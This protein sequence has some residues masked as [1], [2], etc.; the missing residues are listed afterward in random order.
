MIGAAEKKALAKLV[1][2]AT[3]LKPEE[4]PQVN[5][6]AAQP[7]E[8]K[9]KGLT[10]AEAED[11]MNKGE[12][13]KLPEWCGFWFKN[14]K[15]DKVFVFT[16]DGDILDTPH[17]EHKERNDWEVTPPSNPDVSKKLKEFQDSFLDE[18]NE[19]STIPDARPETDSKESSNEIELHKSLEEILPQVQA[20]KKVKIK[21]E[22]GVHFIFEDGRLKR[23]HDDGDAY[24]D[25]SP[26]Y[27]YQDREF[28]LIEE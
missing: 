26:L 11:L 22:E 5:P 21:G 23:F 20:G 8:V 12:L 25:S 6:P 3:P 28:E 17:E 4:T 18:E 13:V 10:Y 7:P 1:K 19:G 2:T 16:K 24:L 9:T 15:A 14:F 27:V